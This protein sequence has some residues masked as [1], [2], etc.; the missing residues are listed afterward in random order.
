MS[1]VPDVIKRWTARRKAAA[2]MDII[3]GKTTAWSVPRFAVMQ[4]DK[5]RRES[6]KAWRQCPARPRLTGHPDRAH[7]CPAKA[8]AG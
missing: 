4:S 1:Q 7:P 3:I 8:P 5:T 2:L 6:D